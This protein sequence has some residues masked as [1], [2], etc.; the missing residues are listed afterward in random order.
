MIKVKDINFLNI[1]LISLNLIAHI[2]RDPGLT[3]FYT[4]YLNMLL[5]VYFNYLNK[6]ELIIIPLFILLRPAFEI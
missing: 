2:L 5:H 1:F 3:Y 4:F 6:K